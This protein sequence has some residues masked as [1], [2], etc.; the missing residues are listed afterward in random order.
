MSQIAAS[1]GQPQKAPKYAPIYQGRFFNGLNTNRSPLRAASA[2][3]IAEKYYSDNSGDALIAGSNIEVSNRLT[4]IRRP[5]NPIFDQE[6][7]YNDPGAF[8]EFRVNKAQSDAFGTT[9][10]SIFTM[11]DEDGTGTNHL[12]SLDENF[13]RGGDSSY[14]YGLDYTKSA[15]AGQSYMQSV[16]NSLYFADGV[17]N[18]K[19]L[20]SLFVRDS[21]G[22]NNNLQGVDGLAG[23]YPFGTYLVDPATGNLQQFI[24]ISIG[25]VTHVT[26]SANVLTLTINVTDDTR[27]YPIGTSFQLWGMNE[28]AFLNGAT[29]TLT[30][31]YDHTL[32]GRTFIGAFEH[33]NVSSS[34]TGQAFVLQTGTLGG[35]TT[36]YIAITG[37]SVP[38]W[39]TVRPAV[40]NEFMGSLTEDGNTVWINRGV[41]YGDGQQP[42]VMKWGINP[43]TSAPTYQASGQEVSW[44]QNTYYSPASVRIDPVNG[45]LWRV[46][47]AG[48]TGSVEP[49]WT[50]S[51]TPQQKVVI[52]GVVS[53]GVNIY[54][55]TTTQS[56]ALVA[57]DSVTLQNMCTFA[58]GQGSFP[59]LDGTQLTVSATGLTTTTFQAPY[60]TNVIGSFPAF[61][62]EYG[63]AL[64]TNAAS[65]ISEAVHGGTAV[66]TCIQLAPSL[67]WTAHTHY[68]VGD[69]IVSST[70][71]LFQLGPK[72]QPFI[73]PN[74]TIDLYSLE[75]PNSHQN[76]DWQGAFLYF[77]STDPHIFTGSYS[78][79]W[80]SQSPTHSSLNGLWLQR[81]LSGS[82]DFQ[83]AA[84]NGA[85]EVGALS[86]ILSGLSASWVG[87]ITTMV[88]I[89]RGGTYTFTSQHNDGLI[90]SFDTA[91]TNPLTVA[92][93]ASKVSGGANNVPQTM[94]PKMGYGTA[95]SMSGTN[96]SGTTGPGPFNQSVN[97]AA[98]TAVWQFPQAGLYGLEISFAKWYHSG[99]FM[100]F[101]CP[102]SGGAPAQTLAVGLDESGTSAPVF[103][104]FTKSGASYDTTHQQIVWGGKVVEVSTAGQQYLWNNLGPTS[105][106]VWTA[107]KTY[108][109]PATSI[110]DTN[111]N[112]QGPYETGITGTTQPTW[113]NTTVGSILA[114]PSPPLQWMNEGSVPTSVSTGNTITALSTQ[115]WLYWIAL[116]N[117]L[118]Q[119]VSNVGPVSA[120]TGPINKGQV[121]FGPGSGLD[122]N[123]IDP[124]AD[125]VA[126]F[127]SADGFTT[128]LLIPG[129]VNSPYTVPL[130]QYLR[131]GYVD[132]VPDVELNNL[133]QGAQAGENTPPATG[134]INLSQHLG[135]I[136]YSIG[137]TVYWTTGPLAPVG[138]GTDG[139]APGNFAE[140]ASQVRRLVPTA[141]G[142]LVFT[143]SDVYIIAGS[144]TSGSPILPAIPYLTGVGL[145][146]YNA[147]DINGG[148]IG[149]FTTDKQ[150]VIFNPSAGLSYVGYP[151]G[152]LL[153]LNNGSAG[154]S[155]NTSKC[156]VAWH[157]NG[158]DQAWY[159]ADGV[160]GWYK[161]IAT[162]APEQG[163]VAWS[164]FATIA[165]S[166]GAGAIKSVE[167]SPGVHNLLV[168]QT[169][170]SSNILARSITAT[171][172]GGTTD[173]NG[174]T[175][176]AY[177]VIGSIVL[178]QPGQVAKV[179][180]ITTDSVN[181]GSPLTIGVIMDEALPYYT[182]SFDTLK[183][184]VNDPPNLPPSKSIL[185]QRFYLSD[186]EDLV[187]YCR[188]MQILFQWTPETAMNE[189]QTLTVFGAYE[190]EG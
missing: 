54:F 190:V 106:Y 180:F 183:H 170:S 92:P 36:P 111:S 158:E 187:A 140:C 136:W 149:F 103:P 44:Q 157:I 104:A 90:F 182:G 166:G 112:Q 114:D 78:Y 141:I 1:G 139:T 72:T 33:A 70:K 10:E 48:T 96:L 174:T 16:G 171:S 143:V 4:L 173:I 31:K 61:V 11:I 37:N 25:N 188:H 79:S 177:G 165:G 84:I 176:S 110:I 99:G 162:P 62:G 83:K 152:N 24:G 160:N 178:A 131:Y 94:T 102:G 127:R 41:N 47:T 169:S 29:L 148:L 119:T 163:S 147:L 81:S 129:F 73:A 60:T 56:P 49:A 167:T 145:A 65:T 66:W 59:N 63:Q 123:A 38:T 30:T 93:G 18:R 87:T 8:G 95:S 69:F 32:L 21:A 133:V 150:F 164:P 153:R 161:C 2:S 89:P 105:D 122:I 50:A 5:G 75:E 57:G 26:I 142:M 52:L 125:Y 155:W 14:F 71:Y 42:S 146:N 135:R 55:Q 27:D 19:W 7:T 67:T 138:N 58:A 134:A 113:T 97:H 172:D 45:H 175:Y 117:T 159:L 88:Y 40:G 76:S 23:T 124:Q 43:P 80:Q 91:Q 179:S 121:V 20:T 17:S 184:W 186:D 101:M 82:P 107:G 109:L 6:H 168:G 189:L 181:V 9:L 46:T 137:D 132:T 151:I 98:D 116:V 51:P 64:K 34:E 15:S 118:D 185:A 35:G 144:G 22:N 12:Y 39:G 68:N 108:T 126:I 77:N 85:G 53:D 28:N 74:Q 86:T 130:T 120:A 128:P 3:H 100:I 156:Y 115:G 13:Q 154:T